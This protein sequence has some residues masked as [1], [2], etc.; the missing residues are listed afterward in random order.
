MDINK[1]DTFGSLNNDINLY[2]DGLEIVEGMLEL[3]KSFFDL[4]DREG[5]KRYLIIDYG[6]SLI[7]RYKEQ[8][9]E[10][11]DN[12][13]I[14]RNNK[15]KVEI[16][17]IKVEDYNYIVYGMEKIFLKEYEVFLSSWDLEAATFVERNSCIKNIGSYMIGQSKEAILNFNLR[18]I[19]EIIEA[20]RVEAYIKLNNVINLFDRSISIE[21]DDLKYFI[22]HEGSIDLSIFYDEV[23]LMR[24]AV[25]NKIE[26]LEDKIKEIIQESLVKK[27]L[28]NI[29]KATEE[30]LRSIIKAYKDEINKVYISNMKSDLKSLPH[31]FNNKVIKNEEIYRRCRSVLEVEL[32]YLQFVKMI[33]IECLRILE[34][35][36]KADF[37]NVFICEFYSV[38]NDGKSFADFE[39]IVEGY[40]IKADFILRNLTMKLLKDF[41]QRYNE[42]VHLMLRDRKYRIEKLY[43]FKPINYMGNFNLYEASEVIHLHKLIYKIYDSY[44]VEN[45]YNHKVMEIKRIYMGLDQE[46]E[47]SIHNFS[48]FLESVEV[49]EYIRS[50]L[51]EE[52]KIIYQGISA[53]KDEL[54]SILNGRFISIFNCFNE[55]IKESIEHL[56]AGSKIYENSINYTD[57]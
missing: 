3:Y 40:K 26:A 33:G 50:S 30:K 5:G 8:W 55:M 47:K 23:S 44:D 36:A 6:V 2:K 39:N 28:S 51:Q 4:T 45:N 37:N 42:I 48:S 54:W 32:N 31:K 29:N 18:C 20:V 24:D 13:L 52:K 46:V 57:Y 11:F 1:K 16:R 9:I 21:K 12:I 34:C 25:L 15:L 43:F 22:E 7:E 41:T 53:F 10:I 38:I 27:T 14:F 49:D 17:K 35:K 56:D 19:K